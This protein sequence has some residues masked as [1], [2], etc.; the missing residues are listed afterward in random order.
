MGFE[1]FNED[2]EVDVFFERA[3]VFIHV[4]TSPEI[5]LGHDGCLEIGLPADLIS[6]FDDGDV[7]DARRRRRAPVA[8]VAPSHDNRA[9]RFS[10]FKLRF[11]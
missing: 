3:L 8:R 9:R 7:I 5:A 10:G 1:F 6:A 11:F 2:E 4:A